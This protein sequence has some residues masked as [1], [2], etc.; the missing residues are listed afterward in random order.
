MTVDVN[1]QHLPRSMH[2]WSELIQ[3]ISQAPDDTVEASWLELKGPLELTTAKD[4][5]K[6]AKAILG[7]ANRDPL[8]AGGHLDGCALLLIGVTA[9]TMPGNIRIEDHELIKALEPY[10]G[11][12]AEGPR[13]EVR[14]HRVDNRHDVLIIV[15]DAPQ[16]G[17]PIY[18]LRR[19]FDKASIGTVYAR[20]STETEPANDLAID[21]LS[22]RSASRTREF[23]IA[24]AL[25]EDA[26]GRATYD[27]HELECSLD[28]AV[29]Q[30]LDPLEPAPTAASAHAAA[31][32]LSQP[33]F[34]ASD[35]VL[36]YIPSVRHEET[37]SADEFRAEVQA[38]RA[39]CRGQFPV[40]MEDVAALNHP[41][42]TFTITNTCGRF[43]EDVEINIHID[44]EVWAWDVPLNDEEPMSNLPRPPREWGPW[45]ESPIDFPIFH[46]YVPALSGLTAPGGNRATFTNGGSV[47]VKLHCEELRP[48]ATIDIT[49]DV[50]LMCTDLALDQARVTVSAT[51]RGVHASFT[52]D[53][54]QPISAAADVTADMA[55]LLN[56]VVGRG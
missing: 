43:L 38:W 5:F 27:V 39:E 6:V 52:D 56:Q 51:A 25:T 2:G 33:A 44:G 29:S 35:L 55:S 45:Q 23:S 37:R 15:V 31:A 10:L 32:K 22:R 42:V 41:R 49:E 53:F 1:T 47:D 16:F 13:W 11:R 46:P 34:K 36:G 8:A 40:L 30:Y 4:R 18:P 9:G 17:D 3:A 48:E 19:A 28:E 20:P 14:R 54:T 50:V 12:G 7:F 24:V 21:M 26:I